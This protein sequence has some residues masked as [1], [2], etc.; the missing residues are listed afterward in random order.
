MLDSGD[1]RRRGRSS[2][3]VSREGMVL[4]DRLGVLGRLQA[5]IS[6]S[7]KRYILYSWSQIR[8]NTFGPAKIL[9]PSFRGKVAVNDVQVQRV[10]INKSI[11]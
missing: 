3:G 4:K 9:N 7:I 11:Q 6:Y 5:V 8:D 2:E 10:N 1:R